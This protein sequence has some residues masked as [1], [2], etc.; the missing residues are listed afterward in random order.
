MSS[1][2]A[3]P[4]LLLIGVMSYRSPV[5]LGRRNAMRSLMRSTRGGAVRFVLATE[6]PDVDAASPDVLTFSVP[7]STRV[8]GTFLLNNAFFRHALKL[9]PKVP[10]IGRADDD[11]LFDPQTVL[12]ELMAAAC[13]QP[14]SEPTV[15][16][17]L[18][19]KPPACSF[20]AATSSPST[21]SAVN[22][23]YGDFHEWYMWSPSA[24]QAT[25][26]DFGHSRHTLSM[27][28]LAQVRGR[29]RALPRFQ[30][31]CLH[32]DLVGPYPFAKGP[33]VVYARAVL[34]RV[35][36]RPEFE[37]DELHALTT[38]K[39][40]PLVNVVNGK[41]YDPRATN[42]PRRAVIYDDIYYGY[43][44]LLSYANDSLSLIQARMSEYDKRH[45]GR[46][47]M[48]RGNVR[49]YHKLKTP[50]R[51]GWANKT[52]ESLHAL[53][54]HQRRSFVCTRRWAALSSW[55]V[56]GLSTHPA[57]APATGLPA[58][59]AAPSSRRTAVRGS[60]ALDAAGGNATGSPAAEAAADAATAYMA[61]LAS[62]SRG[63]HGHGGGATLKAVAASVQSAMLTNEVTNAD[64]DTTV[65]YSNAW[66]GPAMGDNYS[67]TPCCRRWSYCI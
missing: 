64:V 2:E 41:L 14:F 4:L 21:A 5:A 67:M 52:E 17:W 12:R 30:R 18:T 50:E 42:H 3:D 29:P 63:V 6:T 65:K 9:H 57:S 60:Y 25:C 40:R 13:L 35:L 23:V 46:L 36:R 19:R 31:E 20:S 51:F 7:E 24:M 62:R 59:R 53:R 55:V 39:R 33:L 56:R 61:K 11:S 1:A 28:R 32:D 48:Q 44:T 47:D 15:P 54:T 8:L 34:R 22:L 58:A 37:A 16:S 26:F 38:R 66:F 27:S 10:F 45:V 49:I 43:L